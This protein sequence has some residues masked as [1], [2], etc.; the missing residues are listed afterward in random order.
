MES[1]N[2]P[3]AAPRFLIRHD[4]DGDHFVDLQ[5]GQGEG[6]V[7][8]LVQAE[9]DRIRR[10][11]RTAQ[12]RCRT[13]QRYEDLTELLG[14]MALH[15]CDPDQAADLLRRTRA[16]SHDIEGLVTSA[17]SLALALD[18]TVVVVAG[19]EALAA[20][21]VIGTRPPRSRP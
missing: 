5:R 7:Y 17:R 1:T 13:R 19:V 2:S 18:L 20:P 11:H 16:A 21:P 3:V 14:G 12:E 4:K 10:D 9:Q 15:P 6:I 8:G